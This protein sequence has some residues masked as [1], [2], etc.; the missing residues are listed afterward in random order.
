M[1]NVRFISLEH[2]LRLTKLMT[3]VGLIKYATFWFWGQK[4]TFLT[5]QLKNILYPKT[6]QKRLTECVCFTKIYLVVEFVQFSSFHEFP[7]LW[8]IRKDSMYV[9]AKKY[10]AIF[11]VHDMSTWC[12]DEEFK[13][14][15]ELIQQRFRESEPHKFEETKWQL[16]QACIAFFHLD[17]Q[18]YR[19]KIISLEPHRVKV[20]F[21][22]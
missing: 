13:E 15:S 5:L 2:L 21:K 9:L 11:N 18:W 22:A 8:L 4:V 10:C 3:R 17:Q 1:L 19:A 6:P 16:N 12:A 14:V 20:R 7:S